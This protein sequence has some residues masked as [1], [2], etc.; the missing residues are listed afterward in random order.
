[1]KKFPT[2]LE[3]VRRTVRRYNMIPRNSMVV[4]GVSGGPDSMAL[5]NVLYELSRELACRL[6]IAH[7][8]HQLREQS[9]EDAAFVLTAASQI[10]LQVRTL[11]ANVKQCAEAHGISLEE[12]GRWT[13]YAFFEKVR[14]ELG[15]QVIATAHHRDDAVETFF[16][17]LLRGSSLRGLGGIPPRRG[18][19]VR[20]LIHSNRGEILKYLHE[21]GIQYV[22]DQ[23]NL[24]SQTDRNFIRNRVFPLLRE[25]FPHFTAPLER[26]MLLIQKE[27]SFLEEEAKKVYAETVTENQAN[28]V[29]NIVKFQLVPDVL[30]ARIL[31]R[32]LYR[33]S[34][35]LVRLKKSH[36]EACLTLVRSHNPS[37]DLQ[38]PGRIQV[39]REYDRLLVTRLESL[40]LSEQFELPVREPG[41]IDIPNSL[42]K[43]ALKIVEPSQFDYSHS[44]GERTAW[45]DADLITFPL[46]VRSPRP[47][48]RM[49]PWGMTG[50]RK[51]KK[52]FIEARVPLRERRRFPLV[53]MGEEILWIPGV[54]RGVAAGV[55]G[56]TRRVLEMNILA[57]PRWS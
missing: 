46:V 35:N 52:L 54:R 37:A 25:R 24:D 42:W 44:A 38:L 57:S 43:L 2:L 12:A 6:V 32:M 21:R 55:K 47:G 13:R 33:V 3:M 10:G 4:V 19:V 53:V 14:E 9:A 40:T 23:T 22:I 41:E 16:L 15:A 34:D 56:D 31:R 50:T 28:C 29:G 36:I 11:R 27:D 39:R 51:L 20:P 30:L 17:R 18:R 1:M 7:V 8:D 48:D 49:R 5:M 45:F 26:T